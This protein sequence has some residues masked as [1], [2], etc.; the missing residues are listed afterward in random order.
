MSKSN[1]LETALLQMIFNGTAI[2]NLADNA[3]VE[4]LDVLYVSLHTADP[5]ETGTASPLASC[6]RFA[7]TF[8]AAASATCVNDAS[9]SVVTSASGTISHVALWDASATATAN[10]LWSGAL[11]TTKN[12]NVGD[13]ITLSTAVPGL[14]QGAAFIVFPGCDHNPDTCDTKFA[15]SLNFGGAPWFPIDN[16]FTGDT[17]F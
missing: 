5:G 4:P 15:N 6:G 3:G 7:V 13:T 16:H 17:A 8:N 1:Y 10:C 12:V 9:A 14:A 11:A 2:A